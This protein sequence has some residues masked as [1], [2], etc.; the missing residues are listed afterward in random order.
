MRDNL[1]AWA[2]RWTNN[3]D[4]P[5]EDMELFLDAAEEALKANPA[6]QSESLGDWSASYREKAPLL[7]AARCFL[8][9]H[10]RVKT[11]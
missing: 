4:I 6:L 9:H 11:L 5:D 3:E 1:R 7:A 8:G 10:K 2:K